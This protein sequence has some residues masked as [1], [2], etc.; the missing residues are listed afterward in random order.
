LK[1][2]FA[3]AQDRDDARA[4]LAAVKRRSEERV[5]TLHTIEPA[6]RHAEQGGSAYPLLTL[7]MGIA[8]HQ[9]M[10]DACTEFEEKVNAP[11]P[12]TRGRRRGGDRN[13]R[14]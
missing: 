8:F 11:A 12:P 6:A 5:S 1:L 10:I 3:D 2:F 9:A 7:Q 14:D 4:L 13:K